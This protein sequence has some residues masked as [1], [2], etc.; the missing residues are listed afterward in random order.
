M[1]PPGEFFSAQLEVV[2]NALTKN[3]F[4]MG[5]FNLDVR[6]EHRDDY[7]YKIPL[8]HLTEFANTNNLVQLVDFNTWS[9]AINRIKKESLLDHVYVEDDAA[10][11]D[12]KFKE[13]T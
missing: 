10:V 8:S 11:T 12:I 13:P 9:R 6:M 4:V 2:R 5:D 1:I 3:C 7:V